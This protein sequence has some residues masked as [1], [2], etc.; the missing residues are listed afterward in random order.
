MC[1]VE[2][3]FHLYPIYRAYQCAHVILIHFK[4]IHDHCKGL[5]IKL[6][7]FFKA[8]YKFNYFN[9]RQQVTIGCAD[10]KMK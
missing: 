8:L 10:I 9:Y 2:G 4:C 7:Q 3:N 6:M 5:Y 1:H